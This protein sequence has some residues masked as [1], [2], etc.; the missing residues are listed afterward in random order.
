M[1]LTVLR[2]SWSPSSV[3]QSILDPDWVSNLVAYIN[4]LIELRVNHVRLWLDSNLERFQ[5]SHAT[6]EDLRRRFDNMVIEMRTNVQLCS[7]QCASCHLL[8][9][10]SRLHEGDHSCQTTHKCVHHCG[11]CEDELKACGTPYV[12]QPRVITVG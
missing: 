5:A 3:R 12:P 2:E 8:C 6:I 7:A 9:V 4:G 10:R 11:F 1:H